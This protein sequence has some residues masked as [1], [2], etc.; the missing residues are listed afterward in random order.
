M[1]K[2][3]ELDNREVEVETIE[4]DA[5]EHEG[6]CTSAYWIDTNIELDDDELQRLND[7]YAAEFAE[8]RYIDVAS[9][10]YD[11]YKDRMKYGDD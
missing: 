8:E 6:Y 9:N 3:Y 4:G 7:V 2:K 11:R 1:K 5:S 10:A